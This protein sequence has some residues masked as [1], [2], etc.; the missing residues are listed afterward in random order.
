M[1]TFNP[2]RNFNGNAE[3][4]ISVLVEETPNQRGLV[5]VMH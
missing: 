5:F 1:T 4:R 3:G 2:Y